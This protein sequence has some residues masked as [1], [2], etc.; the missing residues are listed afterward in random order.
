MTEPTAPPKK[1]PRIILRIAILL[2]LV[3]GGFAL[4]RRF[5]PR[6]HVPDNIIALTGRIEGD[7][8]AVAPKTAGRIIEIRYREGDTV[9][10]GD[11][12]ARLDDDQVRA[13]EEQ[14]MAAVAQSVARLNAARQQ[15]AIFGDQL[16]QTEIQTGQSKLD[17]EGRVRQAEAELAAAE[18]E[19]AQQKSSYQLALFDKDAYTR[20]AKT[21]AVSERQ[22][23]Q[24]VTTADAQAAAVA[25]AERRV[26]AARGAVATARAMLDNPSIRT[27]QSAGI[28]KQMTMQTAEIASAAADEARARAQLTEA[29]ANRRDLTV[30][31]P[32]DGT[33]ISRTAEPGEVIAAGTPIVTLLDLRKVYL[34]G[35][36]PEGQ[37]GRIKTEQPARVYLD[38]NPDHPLDAYVARV[39]P[40]ATFTPENTYFRDDR[41]KQ[42]VGLKLLLKSG[43]GLAKPGMPADG[44]IL[45]SGDSWPE[46]PRVK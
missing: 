17:A 19:L 34:R 39:D 23:K 11:I 35:F 15:T 5:A 37:I 38:S 6:N 33:V 2:L 18:A 40:Q 21:G 44:E 24:A 14:A 28:R 42:V 12:I 31:A 16:Q 22:G 9:K 41:V 10:A 8:S 32:F 20:L 26:E 13:R 29:Q 25:S 36:V 46:G 27:A 3:G 45:V 30:A 43:F 1:F 7:D 4:W